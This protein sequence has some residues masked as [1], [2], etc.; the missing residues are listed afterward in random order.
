MAKI[1]SETEGTVYMMP[2]VAA[3]KDSDLN[4]STTSR[5]VKVI[6]CLLVLLVLGLAIAVIIISVNSKQSGSISSC[7]T[8]SS[9]KPNYTKSQDLYRDL[10]EIEL[11]QVRDYILNVASL[12]ITPFEKAAVNSNYI[13]LIELQNPI[14]D[15]AIAY[16]DHNGPKPARSANVIIFKGAVSPPVVEEILVYFDKP[17]KHELNTLLTDNTIPFHARPPNNLEYARIAEIV[18]DFGEKA[19]DILKE[20]YDGFTIGNCTDR[21]LTYTDTGPTSM[22]SSNEH[23]AFIW[24]LRAVNYGEYLHPV[25][26]ELLI[27]RQGTDVSKWEIEKVLYKGADC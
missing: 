26:L 13:F 3:Q 21:C 23:H 19:H 12:N 10:S 4:D 8:T 18:N 5:A 1:K 11:L 2:T 20:S 24:F 7:T 22:F 14:K 27:Q 6:L 15:D 9:L 25:G 17:M 16:L